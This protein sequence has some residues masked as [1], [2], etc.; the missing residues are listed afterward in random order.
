LGTTRTKMMFVVY[1]G[2]INDLSYFNYKI[3]I[4]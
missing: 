1:N 2:V 4:F 3:V